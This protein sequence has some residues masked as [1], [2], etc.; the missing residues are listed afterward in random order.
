MFVKADSLDVVPRGRLM[1][2][3][4]L[5]DLRV[6]LARDAHRNHF[7]VHHVMAR[8]CLMTLRA[9]LRDGRRMPEFRDR[10]LRRAVALRAAG[11]K[12]ADVP[13][14][15]LVADRAIEQ[16]LLALQLRRERW[17]VALLEPRD[18]RGTRRIVCGGGVDLLQANVREGDVIHLRR[19]RDPALMFEV[20]DSAFSDVRVE[21]TWLALKNR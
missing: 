16:R 17:G 20:T 4:A 21:G 2:E 9:R 12:K 13:I 7:E 10:P 14:F 1:A 18:E 11:A 6:R 15:R 3:E 8:W 19:A 5:A